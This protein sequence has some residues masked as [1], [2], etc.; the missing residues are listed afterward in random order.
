ML[1]LRLI[2]LVIAFLCFVLSAF[3]VQ[4]RI[5]LAVRR[6]GAVAPDADRSGLTI[7]PWSEGGV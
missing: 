2:L 7:Y 6:S 5:N 3:G 4:S 1:T